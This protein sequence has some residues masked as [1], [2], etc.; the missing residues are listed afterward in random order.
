M[1]KLFAFLDNDKV[2][3]VVSLLVAVALW[4]VVIS[5]R[6][7]TDTEFMRGIDISYINS[8]NM[9]ASGL[10]I[11]SV[12]SETTD[13]KISGR[14]TELQSFTRQN[15]SATLDMSGILAPGYYDLPINITQTKSGV[16]V[17]SV[18]PKNI[19]VRVDYIETNKR[20]VEVKF[21]GEA[22]ESIEIISAKPA[23]AS[24]T[25][26][27]PE[28][29]LD[30]ISKA[31]ATINLAEITESCSVN[32]QIKLVDASGMEIGDKEVKVSSTSTTVDIDVI[33]L[34]TVPVQVILDGEVDVEGKRIS[35]VS[36]PK[37]VIL[38][39]D[40]NILEGIEKVDTE[41][42]LHIPES[43]AVISAKLVLPEGVMCETE[44]VS[45]EFTIE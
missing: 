20:E 33:H 4:M 18:E 8:E 28:K 5:D 25:I 34:K 10:N 9:T 7:P 36:K 45:V 23:V 31:V 17:E 3:L 39:G 14:L 27:G 32:T 29:T 35:I 42:I 15:L 11:I 26:E 30:S 19:T 38:K 1:K 40:K 37:D 13:V 43:S 24:V 12:S 22:S 16:S 44:T 41:S 6:N 21:I 2:L